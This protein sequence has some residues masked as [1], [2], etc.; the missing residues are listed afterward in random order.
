MWNLTS[1]GKMLHF[2]GEPEAGFPQTENEITRE[3]GKQSMSHYKTVEVK[4]K[5]HAK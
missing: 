5:G 3:G 1:A 2:S 4:K